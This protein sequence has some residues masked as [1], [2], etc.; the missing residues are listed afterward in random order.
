MCVAL[1]GSQ[2]N[3]LPKGPCEIVRSFAG[4]PLE[5]ERF[6]NYVKDSYRCGVGFG[7][8]KAN[9]ESLNRWVI[10]ASLRALY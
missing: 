2:K 4:E 8:A 5:R 7:A 10:Q 9:L 6:G 1:L 3:L